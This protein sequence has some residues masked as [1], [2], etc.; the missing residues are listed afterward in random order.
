MPYKR[1][2]NQLSQLNPTFHRSSVFG[3]EKRQ[4]AVVVDVRLNA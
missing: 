2:Q 4:W 3:A 1:V